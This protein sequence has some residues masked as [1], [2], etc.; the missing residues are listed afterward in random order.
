MGCSI[1]KKILMIMIGAV[2]LIG[3]TA[4]TTVFITQSTNTTTGE[5]QNV[6][7]EDQS[8][9]N[10]NSTA[11]DEN[12][13]TSNQPISQEEAEGIALAAVPGTII[14]TELDEENNSLYYEVI[15]KTDTDIKEV[16]VN[17]QTGDVTNVTVDF[18]SLTDAQET[19]ILQSL[20]QISK[21]EAEEIALAEVNGSIVYSK[22]DEDDGR[23][24]YEIT[25][26]TSTNMQEVTID[27][28]TG[29]VLEID[30][31]D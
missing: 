16:L 21:E 26:Q 25:I 3:V 8:T 27:G 28:V 2:I 9:A 11:T 4:A 20:V 15:I 1:M 6:S 30:I 12:S 24:V 13:S 17:V 18:D 7:N 31:D 10:E 5:T 23:P 19:E 29:D 14:Q 22:L